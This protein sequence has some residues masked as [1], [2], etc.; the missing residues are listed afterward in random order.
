MQ[1]KKNF[2]LVE[3]VIATVI[4]LLLI[5]GAGYG[6]S[7][8]LRLVNNIHQQD[9]AMYAAQ[10]KLEEIANNIGNIASYDGQFFNVTDDA[11]NNLLTPPSGGSSGHVSVV[12]NSQV[13][14]LYGVNVTISW[15][16]SGSGQSLSVNTAFIK[17]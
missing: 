15:Q 3:A 7:L 4:T 5:S 2:T 9:V 6:I 17:K 13:A 12:Q 14:T 11:G 10:E 1:N 16:Y 8:Y